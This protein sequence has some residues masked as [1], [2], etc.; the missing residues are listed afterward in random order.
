MENFKVITILIIGIIFTSCSKELNEQNNWTTTSDNISNIRST[1]NLESYLTSDTT[2]IELV[3]LAIQFEADQNIDSADQIYY[4][5]NISRI[6]AILDVDSVVLSYSSIELVDATIATLKTIYNQNTDFISNFEVV[7]ENAECCK[8]AV[9]QLNHC[10]DNAKRSF[11]LFS[12]TNTLVAI[13]GVAIIGITTAPTGGTSLTGLASVGKWTV[14]AQTL[15]GANF[16]NDLYLCN[17]D[18]TFNV[19]PCPCQCDPNQCDEW[20]H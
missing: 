20:K 1:S 9:R 3:E 14:V 16:I 11:A 10:K 4:T 6:K 18:Y 5:S 13:V 8:E 19:S 12:A 7:D 2:F 15:A 17:L